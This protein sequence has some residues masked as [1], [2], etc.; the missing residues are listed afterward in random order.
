MTAFA[1][2]LR[3]L[4]LVLFPLESPPSTPSNWSHEVQI[5][6]SF[7]I[8]AEIPLHAKKIGAIRLSGQPP[9]YD[10]SYFIPATASD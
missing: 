1:T 2:L 7:Y 8:V 5:I 9:V 10:P 3:G 4:Q 6:C